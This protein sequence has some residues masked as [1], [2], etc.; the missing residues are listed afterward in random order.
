CPGPNSACSPRCSPSSSH[1]QN[2]RATRE[3]C[4]STTTPQL[5]AS[6]STAS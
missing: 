4:K 3:R 1:H 6:P 5:W 2:S